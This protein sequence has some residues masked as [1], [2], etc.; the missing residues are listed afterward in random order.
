MQPHAGIGKQTLGDIN[1]RHNTNGDL[2]CDS[3]YTVIEHTH[4][5]DILVKEEAGI[6]IRLLILGISHHRD[7]LGRYMDS[8]DNGGRTGQRVTRGLQGLCIPICKRR[9]K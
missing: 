8:Y 5:I 1:L 9:G 2:Q 4:S 3:E 7:D 6:H